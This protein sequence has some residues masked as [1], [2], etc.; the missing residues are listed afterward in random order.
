MIAELALNDAPLD[1]RLLQ[2]CKAAADP[3]R[4]QILR[5]LSRDAFSVQELCQI[6]D[7]RQSGMSHHLKILSQG[8]LITK[9]RE[10]NSLFYRRRYQP[11]A[12]ELAE[13]QHN[14]LA[15]A[16][17]LQL[18]EQQQQRWQQ[19]VDERHERSRLFFADH[20]S[21]FG[22]QQELMVGFAVYGHSGAELL[23]NSQ[24]KGGELAIEIGPGDGT[25]LGE[26]SRRYQ[27]VIALD[28]SAEML[29]KAQQHGAEE[30]LSN[31]EFLLGDSRSEA[32]HQAKADCVVAN[33]VLHHLPSPADIFVDVSKML[34]PGGL[35]CIT[36]LCPHDQNWAREACG[37]QW[38][39]IDPD[40]LTEWAAA[41]SLENGPSVY[42][43]QLNGFRVQVRQFKKPE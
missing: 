7:C 34:R 16:E 5:V 37:D 35:F 4:L 36:E 33:M 25:F 3:L 26:L 21:Q 13:L 30:G 15:A 24:P 41:C 12:P 40:E 42:L 43:A 9:R 19:V 8:G 39:G 1:N 14:L 32:L 29:N 22:E 28:N 23:A 18:D 2:L 20:A 27:R 6:L 11:E 10:G 17:Q 38:L 31:I